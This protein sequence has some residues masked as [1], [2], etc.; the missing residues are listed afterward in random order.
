MPSPLQA[1]Q[2]RVTMGDRLD[3]ST[4]QE[5]ETRITD[6][7][8]H[9]AT[10]FL[11]DLQAV[12]VIDCVGLGAL[13][14]CCRMVQQHGGRLIL[15]QVSRPLYTLLELTRLILCFDTLRVPCP[16]LAGCHVTETGEIL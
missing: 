1:H 15:T 9:G 3:G 6:G 8:A 16:S 12:H 10:A 4:R 7:L 5:L 2:V 13:S 11:L 14:T